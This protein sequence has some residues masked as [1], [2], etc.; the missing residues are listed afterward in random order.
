MKRIKLVRNV[1]GKVISIPLKKLIMSKE[2][3]RQA[4]SNISRG[5]TAQTSGPVEVYKSKNSYHLS[6][7]YHRIVDSILRKDSTVNAVVTEELDN[8]KTPD[9]FRYDPSLKYSGLER[10]MGD[11][12]FLL[13]RL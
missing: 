1:A 4:I 2:E 7:G 8:F 13:K 6:N 3:L 10:I 11:E 12:Q 9:R 5:Y